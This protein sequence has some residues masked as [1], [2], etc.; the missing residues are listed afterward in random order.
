MKN[1]RVCDGCYQM[2]KYD[3]QFRKADFTHT[4]SAE[5]LRIE[6]VNDDDEDTINME[7]SYSPKP[8]SNSIAE[9][10]SASSSAFSHK[11]NRSE[12][13]A[14]LGRFTITQRN[15]TD[16]LVVTPEAGQ[17][18]HTSAPPASREGAYP[19]SERF[20]V[21]PAK[22]K[23]NRSVF[24]QLPYEIILEIFTS[25][26]DIQSLLN[27]SQ[28][29]HNTYD[30]TASLPLQSVDFTGF[31]SPIK[32]V[33]DLVLKKILQKFTKITC[34]D[35]SHCLQ[36]TDKGFN[37]ISFLSNKVTR[38]NFTGCIN[39][40]NSSLKQI[41][42]S[43]PNIQELN[44]SACEFLTN[45]ALLAC[46]SYC[47]NLTTLNISS[48]W[49]ITDSGLMFI[50][51]RCKR[52]NTLDI[53]FCSKVTDKSV[54]WIIRS[55]PGLSNLILR[56]CSLVT[57]FSVQ[58]LVDIR[59]PIKQLD[60]R[61]CEKLTPASVSSLQEY[62]PHI[63]IQMDTQLAMKTPPISPRVSSSDLRTPLA[64]IPEIKICLPAAVNDLAAHGMQTIDAGAASPR[65]Y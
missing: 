43:C 4:T 55:C 50:G 2:I 3:Q 22:S 10:T 61:R 62:N 21:D 44:L 1:S 30:M 35:L 51:Q 20:V 58:T 19:K 24:A 17:E 16:I 49:S 15:S 52:L 28:L 25:Y 48:C 60:L 46:A 63:K 37:M 9:P 65:N 7:E 6:M 42:S 38:L 36:L 27:F 23:A 29:C 34:I 54:T 41:V 39:L 18:V 26:L 14:A 32:N 8:R 57:D 11:R 53:S 12:T 33:T 13:I 5:D 47:R 56:S 31:F 45:E 64:G 59:S 40:R